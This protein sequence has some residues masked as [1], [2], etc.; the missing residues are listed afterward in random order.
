MFLSKPISDPLFQK[1]WLDLL[2]HVKWVPVIPPPAIVKHISLLKDT[3]I[4]S[5]VFI[6]LIIRSSLGWRQVIFFALG[7]FDFEMLLPFLLLA[8][9]K[10]AVWICRQP[11]IFL[12]HWFWWQ[13]HLICYWESRCT[14][15]RCNTWFST[16]SEFFLKGN[17]RSLF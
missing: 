12:H 8:L 17:F 6:L 10:S 3:N 7:D 11:T 13:L 1:K 14:T 5:N 4:W 9:L 2:G 16:W 15:Y